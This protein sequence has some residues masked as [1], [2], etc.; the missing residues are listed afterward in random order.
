MTWTSETVMETI[1]KHMLNECV[2]NARLVELTGLKPK[3]VE[4]STGLLKQH[5]F[6][7]TIDPGCYRITQAG[8]IALESDTNLRSGPKG[9]RPRAP[10]FRNSLRARV[11]NAIRIRKTFSIPELEPLVSKGNEKAVASNIR[12]YLKALEN[13]GYLIKMSKR[14]LGTAITSNGFA[15]WRLDPLKD[16]GPTAPVWRQGK[17]TVFDPNTRNEISLTPIKSGEA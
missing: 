15:R 7:K 11:W 13:A 6:I 1:G 4:N 17:D 2:T 8:I 3:Q 9:K 5:G 14:Q 10:I 16:T 12:K